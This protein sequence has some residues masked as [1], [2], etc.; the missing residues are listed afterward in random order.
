[1]RRS[2]L[3]LITATVLLGSVPPVSEVMP[4]ARFDANFLNFPRGWTVSTGK[5]V[6]VAVVETAAV[7]GGSGDSAAR[8][9]RLAPDA[10]VERTSLA[11]FLGAGPLLPEKAAPKAPA[12]DVVLLMT[13][14][15]PADRAAALRSIERLSG[16]GASVVIPAW[17]GPMENAADD[18]PRI[19]FV[20]EASARGAAIVGA[21]G[22]A[23]QI[24]S[25]DFWKKMPVDT[26]AI[27]E[28]IDGDDYSGPDALL[29]K[30]LEFPAP[31]AA[32][33]VALLKSVE[34][35]LTPVL[36][37]EKLRESGRRVIWTRIRFAGED[38]KAQDWV[39]PAMSRAACDRRLGAWGEPK[40]QVGERFAA[41]SLDIAL[42]LGLPPLAGGEWSRA[43]L[44]AAEARRKATGKG[45]TVAI[46][47][48]MF[49]EKDPSMAGKWVKPGSVIEGLPAFDESGHGT[50]MAH[51]LIAVAPDVQVMPVRIC[52]PGHDG[53]A[54]D[55]AAGIDYAVAH[56]ARIISLSHRAVEPG[57]RTVLD[58][59]VDRAT[60]AGATFVFIHYQG[61][62]P[63]VVVPGPIEFAAYHEDRATVFVIGTNFADDGSFP[64]T[65]GLS[66]T[67]PMVAGVA[68]MMLEVNPALTP[69]RIKEVLS[70]AG[71]DI[72]S[73]HTVLDAA[74]AVKNCAMAGATR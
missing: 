65:W 6:S 23:Y 21:H 2:V 61:D 7:E 56:G 62:R 36:V 15:L 12:P 24:G 40:P 45:V 11:D 63:E 70:G 41:S 19:V 60:R 53:T 33:A 58:A 35:G 39:L 30:P 10:R 48:H 8:I 47:D 54:R 32:A 69:L 18:D 16:R 13:Q 31:Y 46:L 34:T 64:Y 55:Y 49:D 4:T 17:F 29:D 37:K 72:G 71:R 51:D 73:G 27:H 44:R 25:L 66:Q 9:K 3:C 43:V 20:R 59:A 68:A 42:L 50:W 52:G 38:G 28:G 74:M 5:G 14:P 26:F 57:E 1:M 22:R 67:A